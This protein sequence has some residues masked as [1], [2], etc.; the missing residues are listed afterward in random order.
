MKH[1]AFPIGQFFLVCTLTAIC[2]NG[3]DFY[4]APDGNNGGLGTLESPY[5]RINWAIQQA[6]PGDTIHVRGGVYRSAINPTVSGTAGLPIVIRAYHDGTDYEPVQIRG[7]RAIA[8]G[9]DPAATWQLFDAQR[10]IY[11]IQLDSSWNLWVQNA[12]IRSNQVFCDDEILI[13]ARWPN[14]NSYSGITEADL[15]LGDGSSAGSGSVLTGNYVADGLDAFTENALAGAKIVFNPGQRW[16]VLDGVI[17]ANDP[18]TASVTFTFTPATFAIGDHLPDA[19]DRFYLTDSLAFLDAPGEWFFDT[20]GTFG[21][22]YTLY[23]RLADDADP[24]DHVIEMRAQDRTLDLFSTGYLTFAHMEFFGA[25]AGGGLG[26]HGFTFD[27]VT[28][29]HCGNGRGRHGISLQGNDNTIR[30]C[31]FLM[32]PGSAVRMARGSSGNVLE[33][34]LVVDSAYLGGDLPAVT[35]EGADRVADNTVVHSG[36]HGITVKGPGHELTGN[37]VYRFG[38]LVQDIG[39]INLF[40][41]GNQQGARWHR[42]VVHD[43]IAQ[44]GDYPG[45][46]GTLGIRID[47]GGATTAGYNITIDHNLVWGVSNSAINVWGVQ[48]AQLEPG[49]TQADVQLRILNNTCDAILKLV[50]DSTY[51]FTGLTIQNNIVTGELIANSAHALSEATITDNVIATPE[52]EN[53]TIGSAVFTDVANFDYSLAL[54]SLAIDAGIAIPPFTDGFSGTAPDAGAYEAGSSPFFDPLAQISSTQAIYWRLYHFDAFLNAGTAANSADPDH[55]GFVNSL[56]RG[57]GLDPLTASTTG[58]PSLQIVSDA[59]GA[60]LELTVDRD[61]AASDLSWHIATSTD[62]LIWSTIA[63]GDVLIL[64]ASPTRLR[65]RTTSPIAPQNPIRFIRASVE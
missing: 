3:A 49:D 35:V 51:R 18:A 21:S 46:N 55:D 39:G 47:N 22:A 32:N 33:S 30:D 9:S 37:H 53:N 25:F 45:N 57:L 34:T 60:Y 27:H 40:G 44:R 48:D 19:A 17:T 29:R 38:A 8:P 52:L 31:R 61:P 56:E 2:L 10:A 36:G 15:A 11:A 24:A 23:L 26:N 64:E 4:V 63:P 7:L 42:N 65:A 14:I 20:A 1:S 54:D 6:S 62:L 59:N 58:C 5:Q 41:G 50:G 16:F 12:S 43:G 13:E 28:F